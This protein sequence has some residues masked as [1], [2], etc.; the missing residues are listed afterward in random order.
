MVWKNNNTFTSVFNSKT[1]ELKFYYLCAIILIFLKNKNYGKVKRF[2]EGG[3]KRSNQ[4]FER[5]KSWKES[6][7]KECL[8]LSFL[9]SKIN[10]LVMNYKWVLFFKNIFFTNATN[11]TNAQTPSKIVNGIDSIITDEMQANVAPIK[12]IKI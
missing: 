8:V 6:E 7:E 9:T 1:H 3:E 12:L 4:N 2:E 11:E 10:P 5:K